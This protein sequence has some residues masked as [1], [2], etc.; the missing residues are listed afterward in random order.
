MP[1]VLTKGITSLTL[2]MHRNQFYLALLVDSRLFLS[3]SDSYFRGS[4]VIVLEIEGLTSV[5]TF[6]SCSTGDNGKYM[7][8]YG[9][10]NRDMYFAVGDDVPSLQASVHRLEGWTV[11]YLPRMALLDSLLVLPCPLLS[12]LLLLL[13]C[14]Y[15]RKRK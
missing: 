1:A 14:C 13:R 6:T 2:T 4:E 9:D 11:S 15:Y 7:L 10:S 8:A 5:S 12:L 3:V